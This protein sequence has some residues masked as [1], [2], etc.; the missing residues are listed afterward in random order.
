[1]EVLD[2][3]GLSCPQPVVEVQRELNSG[4]GFFEVLMDCESTKENLLRLLEGNKIKSEIVEVDGYIS[5]K[6]RR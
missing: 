4:T 5:C 1:M 2:V 3:R 6:I